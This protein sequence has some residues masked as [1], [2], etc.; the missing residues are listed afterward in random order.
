[1]SGNYVLAKYFKMIEQTKAIEMFS[2]PKRTFDH[3]MPSV[4][5]FKD[6]DDSGTY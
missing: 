1:M 6:N 3:I 5:I 2:E 4:T